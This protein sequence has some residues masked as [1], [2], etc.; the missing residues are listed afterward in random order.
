MPIEWNDNLKTGIPVID[1]QHQELLVLMNRLGR[2]R[3]G[4]ENFLEAIVELQEYGNIH[5][6]TEEEY[7][8]RLKYPDCEE[9]KACHEEFIQELNS[10]PSKMNTAE[11]ICDLGDEVFHFAQDWLL[12]HYSNEDVLLVDYIKKHS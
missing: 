11:D 6:K 3:C 9:H 1:S 8:L 10:I 7:M 12:Q 2:L 4:R 5:F